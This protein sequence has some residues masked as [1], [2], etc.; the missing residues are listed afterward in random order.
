LG[1]RGRFEGFNR[2][3]LDIYGAPLRL[4][5][6]LRVHG[7]SRARISRWRG[8]ES[9]LTGFSQRLERRLSATLIEKLPRQDPSVLT[10]W[11]GLDGQGKR[12]IGE[13]AN[14]LG[15]TPV[16]VQ[17]AHDLL[18]RYLRRAEGRA[19]LERAVVSA[20]EEVGAPTD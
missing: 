6:L 4:S 15:L 10:R 17:L 14:E 3:L 9:W 20:A 1:C 7:V 18:L 19:V 12:S 16:K 13:I 11:Y 5:Y 2:L 8:D